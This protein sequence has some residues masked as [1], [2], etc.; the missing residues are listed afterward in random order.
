[1]IKIKKLQERKVRTIFRA[2]STNAKVPERP[3]PAEQCTTGGPT[4]LSSP[5]DLRTA[6]RKLRKEPGERGTPKSGQV[7]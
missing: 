5:P 7:R 6:M 3:T 1:M 4:L 2:V